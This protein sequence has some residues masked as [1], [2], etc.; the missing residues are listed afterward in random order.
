MSPTD[1]LQLSIITNVVLILLKVGG[2][3]LSGSAG[4][5]ADGFHSLTDVIAM[6][7]NYF[8]MK[9]SLKPANGMAA[10]DNYKKE[11]VGTFVVSFALF[12]VG[13]FILIRSYL[14][15]M[16]GISHSP[17]LGGALIV[18]VA[19]IITLWLYVHSKRESAKSDSPGLAI[20]T[21]QIKLNVLSTMAV[22][23]GILGSCF[24]MNY[25]DVV[26]AIFVSLIILYS[27]VEIVYSFLD[28][29]KKAKL[30]ESQL[31]EIKSFAVEAGVGI[32]RIKTMAIR[33]K[34]WL[35]LEL[36]GS[37]KSPI[38]RDTMSRLK[39]AMLSNLL[40]L[41]N[42]II[43][44]VSRK[45]DRPITVE[46]EDFG[47]ELGVARNYIN[48]V[49]VVVLALVVSAAAFGVRI[50]PKEYHVLLSADIADVNSGVSSQLGRSR[51]FYL[52]RVDKGAGRFIDNNLAFAPVEVDREVARLFKD[53]SVEAIITQNVGPHLFEEISRARIPMYRAEPNLPIHQ[54]IERF[55]QDRLKKLSKPTVNVRFG[56][57]NFRL[58][59]PW[60]NWQSR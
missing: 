39:Y 60:Y 41:D 35:L 45:G 18:V 25:L 13:V 29:T 53:Y 14:K 28:E 58:F 24:N 36:V 12:V 19:F 49:F 20:N 34:L 7:V 32:A 3:I 40:Y 43:D 38:D 10:Y 57:R 37:P 46:T 48:L 33:K 9:T 26:A 11:I 5:V 17:G 51:C 52:Y 6:T 50:L 56:L 1:I 59:R 44:A 4:L 55:Q 21:Q 23:I 30:S 15:L 31:D 42:V 27:S 54:Q 2:G 47:R 22:F 8:G 16:V